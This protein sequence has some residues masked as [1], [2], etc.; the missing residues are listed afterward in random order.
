M[1]DHIS[2][3]NR[4]ISPTKKILTLHPH[5]I[6]LDLTMRAQLLAQLPG[7]PLDV[8]DILDLQF[9]LVEGQPIKTRLGFQIHRIHLGFHLHKA[10]VKVIQDLFFAVGLDFFYRR[11]QEGISSQCFSQ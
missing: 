1:K 5:P 8:A 2:L 6:D 7:V 3:V 9:Q 10:K 4:T 11:F